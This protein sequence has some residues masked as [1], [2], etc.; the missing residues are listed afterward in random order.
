V[1]AATAKKS[2]K[3]TKQPKWSL[4][5]F[6]KIEKARSSLGLS[7]V[8]MSKMLG[9]TNSTYHNWKKGTAVPHET[10][11]QEIVD[12]IA[13]AEQNGVPTKAAKK[14]RST[15]KTARGTKKKLRKKRS[16]KR[17]PRSAARDSG[18]GASSNGSG[19][20]RRTARDTSRRF[21]ANDTNAPDA[22]TP[23]TDT[24]PLGREFPQATAVLTA[25]LA[26]PSTKVSAGSLPKLI[27]NVNAIYQ[28]D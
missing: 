6:N 27:R 14:K 7:K 22:G 5:T 19:N 12:A 8:A 13:S 18:N 20:S 9:V 16:T 24:R 11:Q 26:N 17:V 21:H 4:T 25:Y 15:K 23:Q 3:S 28:E 1:T 2:T 10:A